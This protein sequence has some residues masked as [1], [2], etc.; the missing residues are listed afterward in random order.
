M[1]SLERKK[2]SV[3][4]PTFNLIKGDRKDVFIEMFKSVHA[5]T[6]PNIEHIIIDGGSKDGTIELINKLIK[7]YGTKDVKIISEPDNGITDASIKGFNNSS[8]DY[9]II[10]NSDDYYMCNNALELLANAIE[11]KNVDYACADCWWLCRDTWIA[12][13]SS[14]AYRHPFVI[15][16]WLVK[17]WVF[18]K[19]GHFKPD[20]KIVADFELFFRILKQDDVTG[21]EVHKTLTCLRPGGASQSN[22]KLFVKETLN[23]YRSNLQGQ[24]SDDEIKALHW[25]YVSS[26]LIDKIKRQEKKQKNYRICY[27]FKKYVQTIWNTTKTNFKYRFLAF[28]VSPDK[29]NAGNKKVKKLNM[30]SYSVHTARGAN[31]W[32]KDITILSFDFCGDDK[33]NNKK[34]HYKI[35]DYIK[36]NKKVILISD[37]SSSE[38]DIKDFLYNEGILNDSIAIYTFENY[39]QKKCLEKFLEHIAEKENIEDR[40][41]WLH[42]GL[43]NTAYII[44]SHKKVYIYNQD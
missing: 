20:L 24:Y 14:F 8:G 19:Y 12:D 41:I 30:R 32:D 37:S 6:Y 2:I 23:G 13:I 40:A 36:N 18:E 31:F 27:V 29:K 28:F 38:K 33:N 17:R 10:M 15:S 16:T 3:I 9:V 26:K 42:I 43:R 25:G 44:V 1:S 34:Y 21:T 22:E 35:S 4:T 5:Q 7:Q 11:R 39:K